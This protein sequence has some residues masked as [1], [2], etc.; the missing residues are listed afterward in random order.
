MAKLNQK[1]GFI[2]AGN[3]GLAILSGMLRA[4]MIDSPQA[5]VSDVSPERLEQVEQITQAQIARDNK[6]VVRE[7]DVVLLAVKPFQVAD[8]SDEVREFVREGQLFITICAGIPTRLLE[9][10]LGPGARVVRV[11]PN[12]PSI[13]GCGSAGVA[14]G[15]RSSEKDLALVVSIFEAVGRAVVVPEDQI[16]LI[17]GLTGSGPAYVYYFL[18][19][20]IDAGVKLG[21]SEKDAMV[22]VGEM[23]QGASRMA[24]ESEHPLRELRRMVTTKGGTTEAGLRVLEGGDFAGMIERCVAAATARSKELAKG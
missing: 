22:L 6:Q 2:G 13:I 16:D 12:T 11:M 7:A 4:D 24:M 15:A 10:K 1:I 19:A 8:V 23:V 20:L 9:E 17:T 14:P 5:I 18:E 21:L 3:M